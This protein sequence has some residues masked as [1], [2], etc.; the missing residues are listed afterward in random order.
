LVDPPPIF[1]PFPSRGLSRFNR[2]VSPKRGFFFF[3]RKTTRS[4]F[5]TPGFG[6][7]PLLPN[8]QTFPP[9]AGRPGPFF[10]SRHDLNPF[11]ILFPIRATFSLPV[12]GRVAFSPKKKVFPFSRGC[13]EAPGSH[14]WPFL[15]HK[16]AFFLR[17]NLPLFLGE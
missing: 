8:P 14:Q 17:A 2:S 15:S 11:G 7:F 9:P 3:L 13:S 5:L 6:I 10:F 12:T 4:L 16:S 1:A